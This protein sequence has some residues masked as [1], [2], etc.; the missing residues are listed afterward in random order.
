MKLVAI[1]LM[2]LA[3]LLPGAMPVAAQEASPSFDCRNA[4]SED[5]KA[6]CDSA[7]LSDLDS[8]VTDAYA[9][10]EPEFS[11]KR[12][13][14]H[15]ILDDRKHCGADAPC[16]AA[17]YVDALETYSS[18]P[19]PLWTY[20]YAQAMML[21]EAEAQA[22]E[23]SVKAAVPTQIGDCGSTTITDLRTRFGEPLEGADD[24]L[25]SWV[26]FADGVEQ[27]SYDREAGMVQS[28]VGDDVLLCLT[29]KPRDCPAGDDRGSTYLA[30]NQ[31]RQLYWSLPGSLHMCG[32]A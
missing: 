17:V 31:T 1:L 15:G 30:L 25:G 21:R 4:Q 10:F 19:L 12:T 7:E 22:A 28:E 11:D 14:A 13:I 16:I 3:L 5:E 32:G 29:Q 8:M 24:D 27:F 2:G 23:G 18:E 26:S 20:A 6:V 9:G